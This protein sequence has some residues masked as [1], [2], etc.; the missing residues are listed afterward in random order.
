VR[1]ALTGVRRRSKWRHAS[2]V[3]WPATVRTSNDFCL[4]AILTTRV[5]E[6]RKLP[7]NVEELLA[8]RGDETTLTPREVDVVELIAQGLRNKEIAA[9]LGVTEETAKSHVRSIFAKAECQR[10]PS[11]QHR[12]TSR[13]IHLRCFSMP[14]MPAQVYR[15]HLPKFRDWFPHLKCYTLFSAPRPRSLQGILLRRG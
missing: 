15:G 9:A 8:I 3:E 11:G 2:P 12:A 5:Y 10:L 7:R 13:R 6:I 1:T 4:D 14:P